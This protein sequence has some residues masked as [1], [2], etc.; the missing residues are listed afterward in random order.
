MWGKE[1]KNSDFDPVQ[2]FDQDISVEKAGKKIVWKQYI[3]EANEDVE[4]YKVMEKYGC[5]DK[6]KVDIPTVHG[7]FE[8]YKDL[9]KNLDREIKAKEMWQALPWEVRKE[10]GNDINEFRDNGGKW[11]NEK[12]KIW[13][14]EQEK[15]KMKEM[16]PTVENQPEIK[17]EI[18]R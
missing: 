5:L 2:T 13:T 8:E 7:D 4:P 1:S 10:F 11:I 16:Q 17:E 12:L 15:L 6:I 9:R 14:A 3:R 18:A